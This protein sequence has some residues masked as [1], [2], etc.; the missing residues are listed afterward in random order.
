[1]KKCSYFWLNYRRKCSLLTFST[2]NGKVFVFFW[3]DYIRKFSPDAFNYV[4]TFLS[5]WSWESDWSATGHVSLFYTWRLVM[6]HDAFHL[7]FSLL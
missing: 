4:V 7:A 2:K 5:M 3:L 1:M 6:L